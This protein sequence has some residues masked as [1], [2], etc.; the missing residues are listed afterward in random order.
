MGAKELGLESTMRIRFLPGGKT[1]GDGSD[2]LGTELMGRIIKRLEEVSDYV[3]LDSAPAGLLTDA[4]VLAQYAD[5]AV[6]VV[7]KDFARVDYIMD[8]MEHLAESNIQIIG[9]ILNGV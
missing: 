6:F 3:I 5:G 9:G 1:I 4:V 7:R 2:L 8:G